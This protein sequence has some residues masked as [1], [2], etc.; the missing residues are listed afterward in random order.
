MPFGCCR[1]KSLNFSSSF[2]SVALRGVAK[3]MSVEQEAE[4]AFAP[5]LASP[6]PQSPPPRKKWAVLNSTMN[7]GHYYRIME[8]TRS[9]TYNSLHCSVVVFSLL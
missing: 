5:Q 1:R 3:L 4:T 6:P 9:H 2:F 7:R 8:F